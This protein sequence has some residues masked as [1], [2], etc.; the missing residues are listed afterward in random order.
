MFFRLQLLEDQCRT[1]EKEL[2]HWKEKFEAGDAQLQTFR[3]ERDAIVNQLQQIMKVKDASAETARAEMQQHQ[4]E[5]ERLQKVV[6]EQAASIAQLQEA[7]KSSSRSAGRNRANTQRDTD[8]AEIEANYKKEVSVRETTEKVHCL[9]V[10]QL[11]FELAV[12]A[13][14]LGTQV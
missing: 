2:S 7:E 13:A 9:I 1:A 8:A 6:D 14:T 11:L 5:V 12:R 4:A 3:A 10:T